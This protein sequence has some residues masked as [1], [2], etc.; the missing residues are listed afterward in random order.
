MSNYTIAS[1]VMMHN[2]KLAV[3][4][5]AFAT[6][7]LLVRRALSNLSNQLMILSYLAHSKLSLTVFYRPECSHYHV[8]HSKPHYLWVFSFL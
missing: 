5:V 4:V 1:E 3:E 2:L 7:S 8:Q 6:L